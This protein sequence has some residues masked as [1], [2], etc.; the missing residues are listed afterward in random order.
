MPDLSGP[1]QK[2][3]QEARRTL[4]EFNLVP[5][6]QGEILQTLDLN[7]EVIPE[8]LKA[9]VQKSEWFSAD[10]GRV[11]VELR[12]RPKLYQEAQGLLY[13]SDFDDTLFAATSWHNEE[14][15]R[16]ANDDNLKRRGIKIPEDVGEKLY[17]K[18]KF[19]LRTKAQRYHPKVN[20]IL[21]SI[22]A[23]AVERREPQDQA[24]ERVDTALN[25][26]KDDLIMEGKTS[27]GRYEIDE[28]ILR[29]L[30]GNHTNEYVYPSFARYFS[31][32][33]EEK[34]TRAIVSR[35]T[36][37]DAFG[38][39]YKLHTSGLLEH[40]LGTD[41]VLYTTDLK[42]EYLP[43]LYE[44]LPN[45]SEIGTRVFDDN[46]DEIDEYISWA[47]KHGLKNWEVIRVV[48]E[49]AKRE[50]FLTKKVK[51]SLTWGENSAPR[52]E[53]YRASDDAPKSDLP[54]I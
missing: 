39:V 44:L 45:A 36:I 22:Y 6:P 4:R 2:P 26:I 31:E 7:S 25:K 21:A 38:Q 32:G 18:S 12:N 3:N 54:K 52:F 15:K 29:C 46:T 49:G 34:G 41:I 16:L 17:K 8:S 19:T 1:E 14:F 13:V 24:E 5:I 47:R 33:T 20:L 28:D 35:G 50:E 53:L 10:E 27:L 48:H 40:G 30:L 11:L 42:A 51:P 9:S 23:K 37:E 43:I